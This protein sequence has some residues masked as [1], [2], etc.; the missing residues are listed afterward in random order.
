MKL[1]KTDTKINPKDSFGQG[2]DAVISIVVFVA[3]GFFLDR[4][5][6]TTPWL[7]LVMAVLGGIGVFYRLKAAYDLK[8]DQQAS[9]AHPVATASTHV[10]GASEATASM[11]EVNEGPTP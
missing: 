2:L 9:A 11:T 5:L 7:M 3:I 6:G 8:M 1:L 10:A 4:W